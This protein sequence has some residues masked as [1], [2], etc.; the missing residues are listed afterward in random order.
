[1][2]YLHGHELLAAH[3]LNTP[4]MRRGLITLVQGRAPFTAAQVGQV[5]GSGVHHNTAVFIAE[6]ALSDIKPADGIFRYA[7][8]YS[9]VDT[10]ATGVIS[11]LERRRTDGTHTTMTYVYA[12]ELKGHLREAAL[13][14]WSP[15]GLMESNMMANADEFADRFVHLLVLTPCC[16]PF[17][18]S[19]INNNRNREDQASVLCNLRAALHALEQPTRPWRVVVENVNTPTVAIALSCEVGPASPSIR[20]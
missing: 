8:A 15:Y 11:V 12:A 10:F 2:R 19:Q 16:C 13:R 14:A 3:D 5:V 1:M 9:G 18:F 6:C 4:D 20:G 7:S 17:C